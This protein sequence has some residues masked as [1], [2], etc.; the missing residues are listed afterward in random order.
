MY[1]RKG[2]NVYP[3]E[4]EN[5][6][7]EHPAVAEVAIIGVPHEAYGE[8]GTA[9][10]VPAHG[11]ELPPAAE[12]SSFVRARLAPYKAPDAYRTLAALPRTAMLKVDKGALRRQLEA[13]E[14]S[15][16]GTG[17]QADG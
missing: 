17:A 4:V 9:F 13:D 15:S 12:L 10:V 2:Y 11:Q 7:L 1:I 16:T 8:A 5:V 6:L 14:R 3:L